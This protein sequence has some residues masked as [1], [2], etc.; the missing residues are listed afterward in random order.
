MS[1]LPAQS[2][3][4]GFR[5]RFGE[6]PNFAD[7]RGRNCVVD[8]V[9]ERGWLAAGTRRLERERDGGA[10]GNRRGMAAGTSAT[11]DR[12]LAAF[13]CGGGAGALL[14]YAG[15]TGLAAFFA[16]NANSPLQINLHPNAPVLLFTIGVAV[17]TGIGFGLRRHAG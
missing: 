13:L 11:A 12:E 7:G 15:A 2:G 9:R 3:L 14:A 10:P 16:E 1:L 6:P 17:L 8:C 4:T 5:D